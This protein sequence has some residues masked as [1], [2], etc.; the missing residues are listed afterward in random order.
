[1]KICLYWRCFVML[2]AV[3]LF[4]ACN[5]DEGT[6]SI[7]TLEIGAE[8]VDFEQ[9]GGRKTLEIMSNRINWVAAVNLEARGWCSVT[10]DVQDK[11][12]FME[13]TVN[14]NNAIESREAVITVRIDELVRKLTVRQLGSGKGIFI[15][16]ENITVGNVG[17]T[18]EFTV[19]TNV[20]Y[21]IIP[22]DWIKKAP[23]TRAI[24]W[25]TNTHNYIV[26]R[27]TGDKRTGS[28]LVKENS[29]DEKKISAEL[30]VTQSAGEY[31]SSES[32]YGEDVMVPIAGGEARNNL[33]AISEKSSTPF[34]R[35]W[36]GKYSGT[37]SGYLC[38]DKDEFKASEAETD[39]AK[40][41]WPL[42]LI[43]KFE[44][45]S[46][47][48][49]FIWYDDKNKDA[50]SVG[51]VYVKTKTD[52]DFKLVM[53]DV[54]F[55]AGTTPT[56]IDFPVALIDPIEI[57][58][59]AKTV[60]TTNQSVKRYL[61][62]REVEF[63]RQNPNNF[64]PMTLFEDVTCTQLK[65]GITEKEIEECTDPL[66]RNI[67]F[68]M[69]RGN[70]PAEFRINNYKAYPHPSIFQKENKLSKAHDLLSNPTGIFVEQGKEV[71]IL[72]GETNGL[73]LTA[74]VLNLY[75]PG[76]DGFNKNY[77]HNLRKGTN[78]FIAESDG[79]IYICYHTPDYKTT[80]EIK[81]HIPSGK[82]NGYFDTKIHEAGEWERLLNAA[83][84]PHFDVLGE[85]SHLMFPV[86]SFK[87][88]TPDGK[89]LVDIYDELVLLEQEFMG[90]KKYNRMNPNYVCFSVMYNNSY[91]YA[92][93]YHTGYVASEMND[94]CSVDKMRTSV[95]GPAHEVGHTFQTKPGLCW[96]GMTEVTNNIHSLYVQTT[97][98]N[99]S[100]LMATPSSGKYTSLYEKGMSLLLPIDHPHVKKTPD[101]TDIDLWC[102]LVPFWQLYL[103]TQ[104][105]GNKDFYKDLYQKI[106]ETAD[107][108]TPGES[109]VE[110]TVLASEVAGLDFTEFFTKWGFYEPVDYKLNDYTS[111][112][113]TVT[114]EMTDKAKER[115]K[116]MGLPKPS[117][118]V[119]YICDDN[120]GLY[121]SNSSIVT[122]SASRNGQTFLMVN[123][124]NVAVYEVWSDDKLLFISPAG[125]F[126]LPAQFVLGTKVQVFA[127]A[128]SGEKVEV[129]L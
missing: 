65:A 129:S 6:G 19:T 34:V 59:V 97:F 48:D 81:I 76:E 128:P 35:A 38:S 86:S 121:K 45:Q 70:Y 100:R 18:I 4:S 29:A 51:D 8:T 127:V 103:Y 126:T 96:H 26:D 57:K 83:V 79:L 20:E 21:E 61:L 36:D 72:V 2:F 15:S 113:F 120:K 62:V 69:L 64:D 75:V 3:C 92:A 99:Q 93:D 80:P 118:K 88:Y 40:K 102:Q 101:G 33:G 55:D 94:L 87:S 14:K 73:P 85:Y 11:K 90:L 17:E 107:K 37:G 124:K 9:E 32:G 95:W 84:A 30:V 123:W 25:Q 58:V 71:I 122:G 125:T 112:Q 42:S 111:K 10:A 41:T 77:S 7:P 106:R 31:E 43:F 114:K 109:Q 28:I 110:F 52:A 46:R 91:M 23:E 54:A 13:I 115:I 89:A 108:D 27:N 50:L 44:D 39:P 98:G 74:R 67:A 78:R 22:S 104:I 105:E 49:Y 63:Y 60:Y 1:M 16:P 119:E 47:I 53:K 56:R 66:F 68:Y 82:V 24:E 116:A 12:Q 5:D 117:K